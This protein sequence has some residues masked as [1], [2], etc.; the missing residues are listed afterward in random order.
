MLTRKIKCWCATQVH[1]AQGI[2]RSPILVCAYLVATT[3]MCALEAIEF[4]QAKRHVVSPNLAFRRQLAQWG[5][6]FDEK[7]KRTDRVKE[8]SL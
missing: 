4:V 5:E 1:C 7:G 8:Q 6:Q 3:P 2:S